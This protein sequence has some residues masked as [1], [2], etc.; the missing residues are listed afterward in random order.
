LI[1]A[2]EPVTIGCATVLS[3]AGPAATPAP[4]VFDV[5]VVLEEAGAVPD[6]PPLLGEA[7]PPAAIA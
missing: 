7:A 6:P 1:F 2:T 3:G 4:P 5:E